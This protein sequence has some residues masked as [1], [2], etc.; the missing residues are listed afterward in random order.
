[1][2]A[3]TKIYLASRGYKEGDFIPCEDCGATATEIHHIKGRGMGGHNKTA[4]EP[5]NLMALCRACH[6]KREAHR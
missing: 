5:S 1:M 3:H 4:N 2:K 6:A